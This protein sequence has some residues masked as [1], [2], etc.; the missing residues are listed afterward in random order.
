MN[1]V[2]LPLTVSYLIFLWKYIKTRLNNTSKHIR[3]KMGSG[4]LAKDIIEILLYIST[5]SYQFSAIIL[6]IWHV[7]HCKKRGGG[8]NH[9]IYDCVQKLVCTKSKNKIVPD[10]TKDVCR[11]TI[12]IPQRT[13]IFEVDC[14]LNVH[15]A[16]L[17]VSITNFG[18]ST[19]RSGEMTNVLVIKVASCHCSYLSDH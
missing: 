2:F 15:N 17:K 19:C 12:E 18:L 11:R 1:H 16:H 14:C 7:F 8:R 9:M 6:I 4:W 5:L 13:R 10:S 3:D